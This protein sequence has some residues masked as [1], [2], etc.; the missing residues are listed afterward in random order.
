MF[1]RGV[2][3]GQKQVASRVKKGS[4]NVMDEINL[5][6][7]QAKTEMRSFPLCVNGNIS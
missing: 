3:A 6:A 5:I 2:S 1:D 7:M 4:G